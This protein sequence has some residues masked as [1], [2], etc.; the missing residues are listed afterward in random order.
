MKPAD[1]PDIQV[2]SGGAGNDGIHLSHFAGIGLSCLVLGAVVGVSSGLLGMFLDEVEK[3]FLGFVESSSQPSPLGVPA[4]RRL[5]SVVVGGCVAACIWWYLRN[6]TTRVPSVAQAVKGARM[7]VWQTLLHV[8]TQIFLVGTGGAIG[9]EVA[10][11]EAGA[12]LGSVWFRWARK[13]GLRESDRPLLVAAAAGAGFAGI[14]ISPLT[15][16]LF[17]LEIL[18]ASTDMTAVTVCLTMSSVATL[19]GG[20]IKGFGPYYIVGE[21]P[22]SHWTM[23]FALIAGLLAGVVGAVFRC[24]TRW[25]E[26]NQ[27]TGLTILWMLPAA[28]LLTGLVAWILPEVMGNGRAIAQSAMRLSASSIG[29]AGNYSA[30]SVIAFFAALGV[31]K[32]ICTSLTIRAGASGGTLTPSIGIGAALGV[33]LGIVANCCGLSV[34]LWQAAI[35]GAA[36]TLAASQQAP[37]M[38]LFMLFEICHLPAPALL[39]LSLAVALSTA[40]SHRILVN[41]NNS[42]FE[43]SN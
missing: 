20:A 40:V 7:P 28:A 24:L 8:I 41:H 9:R 21:Q 10:P 1:H 13:F 14:Y 42:K 34:P 43:A 30:S 29:Q 17:G 31:W 16:A 11:R 26:T 38:A 18:L 5:I 39:P 4:I 23:L 15:G 36:S 6:K 27:A 37:L 12:M 25:A 2:S 3:V 32:F 33:I 22:F 19:V 35:I